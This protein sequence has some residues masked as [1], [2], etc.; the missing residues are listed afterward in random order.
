MKKIATNLNNFRVTN[1]EFDQ[2]MELASIALDDSEPA[3]KRLRAKQAYWE[4]INRARQRG[5]VYNIKMEDEGNGDH[6]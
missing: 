3:R 6:Y 4:I 5:G 2:L 1:E